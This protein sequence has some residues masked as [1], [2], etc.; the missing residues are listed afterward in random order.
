MSLL[1]GE[2]RQIAFVVRDLDAALAY[3][4]QVLGVGP[5]FVLR[6]ATFETFEV[7]G[8]PSPPP[9]IQIALGNS[10]D[11]QVELIQQVGDEPSAYREFLDAG[12]EGMH[13]VSSWLTREEYDRVRTELTAQGVT[14]SQEGGVLGGD[15]RFAYFR[16]DTVDGGIQYEIADVMSSPMYPFFE[17]MAQL[18]KDWDG[19]DP[20]REIRT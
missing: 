20:I 8:K 5:F 13:H 9:T 14:I 10:G 3:W 1:F 6:T 12:R 19:T 18:A 7:N 2:I 15:S 11:L 16:T 4:T 17:S